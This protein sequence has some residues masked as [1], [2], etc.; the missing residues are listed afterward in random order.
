MAA[1]Q[2]KLWEVS[3]CV[4]VCAYV[5][6]VVFVTLYSQLLPLQVLQASVTQVRVIEILYKVISELQTGLICVVC[7][8]VSVPLSQCVHMYEC[9]CLCVMQ[10]I[11]GY[12]SKGLCGPPTHWSPLL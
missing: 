5:R 2:I 7:F 8:I 3:V 9:A 12:S 11:R 1:T 6:G 4:F 10:V